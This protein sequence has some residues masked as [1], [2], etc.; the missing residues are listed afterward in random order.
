MY[1]RQE[2]CHTEVV[3]KESLHLES[4]SNGLQANSF[5]IGLSKNMIVKNTC[6]HR[7]DIKKGMWQSPDGVIC[8]Q[9]D[10]VL[11]DRRYA[12]N[13]CDIHSCRGADWDSDH[14]VVRIK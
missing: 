14:Y 7:K 2:E 10:H 13:I 5:A 9:I 8:N 3:G 1:K 11:I 12:S 4:N 6:L